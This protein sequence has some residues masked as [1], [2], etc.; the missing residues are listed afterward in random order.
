MAPFNSFNPENI[1]IEA[2]PADCVVVVGDTHKPAVVMK[3]DRC[4]VS[5][6]CLFPANKAELLSGEAGSAYILEIDRLNGELEANLKPVRLNSRFGADLT[7][8]SSLDEVVDGLKSIDARR[9]FPSNLKPVAFVDSSVSSQ[10]VLSE[11][12]DRIEIIPVTTVV[13]GTELSVDFSGLE[14]EDVTARIHRILDTIFDGEPEKDSMVGLAEDL[15]VT[16]SPAKIIDAFIKSK[17]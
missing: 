13:E 4:V 5:P 12:A 7:R 2:A 16:D 9:P 8:L 11:Y 10:S 15:V 6:G 3:D 1:S 17:L 14:G